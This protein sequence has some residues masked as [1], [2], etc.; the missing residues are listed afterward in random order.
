MS[1]VTKKIIKIFSDGSIN[2]T[3]TSFKKFNNVT[4]IQKDHTTFIFNKKNNN[5]I[6]EN[7]KNFESFKTRYLKF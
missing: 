6:T 3:K 7:S 5:L 4:V 1:F 2:F